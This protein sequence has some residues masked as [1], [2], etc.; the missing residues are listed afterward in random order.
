MIHHRFPIFILSLL[1]FAVFWNCDT[2]N[3]KTIALESLQYKTV[4]GK[5]DRLYQQQQYD[6]AFYYYN[7]AKLL[8]I[9][10][11]NSDRIVYALIRMSAIQQ[12][13]SDFSGSEATATEAIDYFNNVTVSLYP[14]IIYNT[15]GI[16][17]KGQYD[18][19]NAIK[20][21][22][23][24][25]KSTTDSLSRGII[26]NN[27]AV[28]LLEEQK[29]HDA[30]RLLEPLLNEK[31]IAADLLTYAKVI[32]NLGYAYWK[33]QQPDALKLLH[34][35]LL[36]REQ[37]NNDFELV[38]SYLH[39]SEYYRLTQPILAK[40]YLLKAYTCAT[41]VNS[42]DDRMETLRTLIHSTSGEESNRYAV[43]QL[44]LSDSISKIR[45]TAKNQ[46][47]KIRYDDA[48]TREENA[49]LVYQKAR[50]TY[51]IIILLA[52]V[53]I[54]I[55][56]VFLVRYRKQVRHEREKLEAVHQAETRISR[57]IH[58]ELANDL[59]NTITFT[60]T[61]DLND[62]PK[63]EMLLKH[64][65]SVYARARDI[66]R[67][68]S[69]IDTG[70]D[71]P[72]Q[73]RNMLSDYSSLQ[74]KVILHGI[75]VL[76]W[77]D[78]AKEKKT[79]LYRVLQELMVNMKKHSAAGIVMLHFEI[80]HKNLIVRYTDNGVGTDKNQLFSKN[81]LRNVENRIHAIGGTFTFD[82]EPKNGLRVTVTC[83]SEN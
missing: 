15:L 11:D 40:A 3:P 48:K 78:L 39:L 10:Q 77:D 76:Q 69:D 74:Q 50:M 22:T 49:A 66:S 36:L 21:Y 82:S 33:L 26:Q 29:Y 9:K 44:R 81:G 17:Y 31:T 18:Y 34:Q 56:F 54:L 73:L 68:N 14:I 80:K 55:L 8:A 70:T 20:Y 59:Y 64:L 45:L 79:I 4:L 30:A 58:D 7:Q 71:F 51:L 2:G 16:A 32:D 37:Q 6:S 75:D 25:L 72:L 43:T 67:E 83:P 63:K 19:A 35:S 1:L 28:I 24:S 13:Q 57:K 27:I 41:R 47:A 23:L 42:I 60:E 38:S 52:L 12:I 53:L 46:F 61:Q 62:L 65:D 5:A